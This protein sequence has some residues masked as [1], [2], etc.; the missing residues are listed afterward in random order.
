MTSKQGKG[1]PN[2][3]WIPAAN[4]I[5]RR[6]AKKIDGDPGGMI[7]D[8]LNK[9][10]T[11]HFIGGCPIGDSPDIGVVDPYQ[12]LY[13]HPGLHV[14]DGSTITANLGVNPSLTITAQSERAIAFWPNNGDEDRRPKLGSAYRR[15][16]PVAP[17]HPA[18]PE[19]APAALRLPT[20]SVP[21]TPN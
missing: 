10:M 18:V 8:I 19:T 3:N 4:D 2:P 16:A 15:I 9:P 21:R 11:A 7:G 17:R 1:E 14:I 12:R 13:G 6:A 20:M 5:A